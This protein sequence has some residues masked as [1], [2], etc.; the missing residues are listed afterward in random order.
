MHT[1]TIRTVYKYNTSLQ[2]QW[3]RAKVNKKKAL[4]SSIWVT[5]LQQT[6]SA[7][8]NAPQTHA[9]IDATIAKI[10]VQWYICKRMCW[11][12][13]ACPNHSLGY[14][15]Q[16]LYIHIRTLTRSSEVQ[17]FLTADEKEAGLGNAVARERRKERQ[18][19]LFIPLFSTVLL[20]FPSRACF[21]K[22]SGEKNNRYDA[23]K[24]LCYER[25]QVNS[26]KEDEIEC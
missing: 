4:K 14:C 17:E 13:I 10:D 16:L 15:Y 25:A 2:E 6:E 21:V 12:T 11:R 5:W 22:G 7:R 3:G 9:Y 26:C 19:C 23:C 8:R 24:V 20:F 1:E 18:E